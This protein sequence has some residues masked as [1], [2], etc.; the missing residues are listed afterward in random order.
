MMTRKVKFEGVKI[1]EQFIGTYGT[2]DQL[3]SS[4]IKTAHNMGHAVDGRWPMP[5]LY[6]EQVEVEEGFL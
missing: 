5:F 2:E 4:F 3:T 1:G 6:D